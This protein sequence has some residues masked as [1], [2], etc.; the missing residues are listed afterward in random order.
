M[1]QVAKRRA[2]SEAGETREA[3]AQIAKCWAVFRRRA[4]E[5][6]G[7]KQSVRTEEKGVQTDG[8]WTEGKGVQTDGAWIQEKGVQV[9]T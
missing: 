2:E 6:Q 8:V 5:K 7:S 3:V 9:D 4:G 1:A